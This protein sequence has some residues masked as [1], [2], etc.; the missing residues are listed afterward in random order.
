MGGEGKGMTYAVVRFSKIGPCNII[1]RG[2]TLKEARA[3]CEGPGTS[4]EGWFDGF[5][6]EE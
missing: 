5:K 4:G 6:K 2:L 3:A 1:R